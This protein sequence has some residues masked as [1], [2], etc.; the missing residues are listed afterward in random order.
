MRDSRAE[1]FGGIN[2][3]SASDCDYR[4]RILGD[5]SL[6][7]VLDILHSGIGPDV[8]ENAVFDGS[9]IKAFQ[10]HIRKLVLQ[11]ARIG[12]DQNRAF[13]FFAQNI[14]ERVDRSENNWIPVGKH[15]QRKPE[16]ALERPAPHLPED[17]YSVGFHGAYYNKNAKSVTM[18]PAQTQWREIL[19][20]S[21]FDRKYFVTLTKQ[22]LN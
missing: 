2:G 1:R 10:K 21:K 19:L 6:S 22:Y 5:I 15:R 3:G 16:R 20:L 11:H 9:A 12:N 18:P 17:A 8:A 4:I 7:C 13:P 14:R